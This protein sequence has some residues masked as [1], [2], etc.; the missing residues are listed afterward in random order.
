[1]SDQQPPNEEN[2]FEPS[3]AEHL[4]ARGTHPTARRL[5]LVLLGV[6][7]VPIAT[8]VCGFVCCLA[9]A[10]STSMIFGDDAAFAFGFLAG[11]AGAA[12]AAWGVI[13]ALRRMGD[14]P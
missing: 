14:R 10:V 3:Q 8:I 5:L 11:V 6:V 12:F 1:M 7:L 4:D 2:P 13:R 9:T